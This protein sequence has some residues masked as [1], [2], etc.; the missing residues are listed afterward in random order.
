MR[1]R[2]PLL[3][4]RS[5][6]ATTEATCTSRGTCLLT[7]IGISYTH[8]RQ[9]ITGGVW[10]E[11]VQS[12]ELLALSQYGQATFTSIQTLLAG[13]V[14]TLLYDPTPTEMAW[15]SLEGAAYIQDMIKLRPGLTL[16]L[17]FR[18]EFT[19]GW[20]EAT[21]RAANYTY[22]NG[23]ISSPPNVGNSVFTVNNAKFL[24]QPRVGLAWSPF[25]NT[26][27][28]VIRAGFGM[29]NDLQDALGYRTDQNAPFNPTY[30]LPTV[31]VSSLPLNTAAPV[32]AKAILVPGG[33]QPDLQTPTLISWT[34]RV[35]QAL[36]ANTSLTVGYVGS[37][38]YH[39]LLGIDANE[40]F[41]VICP[42]SPCPANY[43]ANFPAALAGTPIPAGTY[44]E[45]VATKPNAAHREH[46]DL[47][48]GGR[49]LLQRAAGGSE[50]PVQPRSF[51]ARRLHVVEND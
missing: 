5:P 42:A 23:I 39:E 51:G 34:L 22:P 14:A 19:T 47:F 13:T 29:Y 31:P 15:R 37:H 4:S 44:Y 27:R 16:S 33:V 7:L 38:G 30:S 50:S 28:T 46:V 2:I 8:G 1:L 45:P 36:T 6:G 10:F 17:G 24:P 49:Q 35:Q 43:P 26:S 11:R 9:Q 12:N 48:L 18:D 20:N 40:P 3:R 25:H 32:P 21:G 41:P